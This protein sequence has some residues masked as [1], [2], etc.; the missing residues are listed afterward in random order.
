MKSILPLIGAAGLWLSQSAGADVLSASPLPVAVPSAAGITESGLD[1]LHRFMQSTTDSG[2]YLGAVTLIARDG[3]LVDWRAFGHR[4]L[5]RKSPLQPDAIFRIY[6]MTKTVTSVAVLMLMEEDR[7]KLDD[8]ISNHLPEFGKMQVF[9]GGTANAPR[10]RPATRPITIRQLLTHTS[11]FA[12]DAKEAPEAVKLLERARLHESTDLQ[13]Y[14]ARLS[15]LPLAVD[16]GTRFTYDGVQIVV[17]SRLVEVAANMSF[18]KFLQQRIFQPLRLKDTGFSVPAEQRD[19]IVEMSSTDKD[20]RLIPAPEYASK[21]A[22]EMINPYYSGA[23]GLYSTAADYARFAQMLLN[24][25]ELDGASILRR[26]TVELM[27]TNQLSDLEVAPGLEPG[28]FRAGEGFGLGGYVVLDAAR[29]GR[30]GSVGQFGW[31]GAASTYYMIDPKER[32]IALLFM[33]HLPQGL[34]HDPPKISARFYNL[35]HHSLAQ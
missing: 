11:G 32:L 24:G 27:M 28:E 33:Q 19:R 4:D 30:E 35:V 21:R 15:R 18:E 34:P 17:L 31:F 26:K 25:G 1:P 6:S 16:P 3:K 9:A 13:T 5:A 14:C 8:P 10:L 23:G 29:R 12:V 22:G 20:G 2:D 7:F